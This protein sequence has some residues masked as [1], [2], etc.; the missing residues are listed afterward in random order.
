[1]NIQERLALRA[2]ADCLLR[3]RE[4]IITG[5]KDGG[6]MTSVQIDK[7]ME[8]LASGLNKEADGGG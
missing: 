8:E 6:P 2:V 7:Y 3:V 4:R 1:M 5:G